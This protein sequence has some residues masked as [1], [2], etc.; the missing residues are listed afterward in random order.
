ML[1]PKIGR[2]WPD[3]EMNKMPIYFYARPKPLGG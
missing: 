1:Q 3:T 2:R